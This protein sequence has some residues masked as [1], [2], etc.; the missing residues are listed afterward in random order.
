MFSLKKKVYPSLK[1]K[2]LVIVLQFLVH[3]VHIC[4][5]NSYISASGLGVCARERCLQNA[6]FSTP[7]IW[8]AIFLLLICLKWES[9]LFKNKLEAPRQGAVSF[10]SNEAIEEKWLIVPSE[11]HLRDIFKYTQ[12]R[13]WTFAVQ[14]IIGFAERE[15]ITHQHSHWEPCK[16]IASAGSDLLKN[17]RTMWLVRKSNGSH[18]TGN[19]GLP[20]RFVLE[21]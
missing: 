10:R 6:K 16:P 11:K 5:L 19:V 7:R 20:H 8:H 12:K 15:V 18:S 4:C 17:K 21:I 9:H 3:L 14:A 1:Q 13:K 2:N